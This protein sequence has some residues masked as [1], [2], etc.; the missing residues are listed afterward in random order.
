M[1]VSPQEFLDLVDDLARRL[2]DHEFDVILGLA[3]GGFPVA[4]ALAKRL[5][6][7]YVFGLP[8]MFS[9]DGDG[10]QEV[11]WHLAPLPAWFLRG[12]KVL[13]VDDSTKSGKMLFKSISDLHHMG[14]T[15]AHT[16]ALIASP[17]GILPTHYG[18]LVEGDVEFFW[19]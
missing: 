19:E 15:G 11:A 3:T 17:D 14:A 13:V 9:D 16:L 5:D 6:V 10:S 7:E 12:K 4:A 18:L 1:R 2:K 8:T